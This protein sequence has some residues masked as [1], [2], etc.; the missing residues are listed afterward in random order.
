M[1]HFNKVIK[2][3]PQDHNKA[4]YTKILKKEDGRIDWNKEAEK[5]ERMITVR[6][7]SSNFFIKDYSGL[8]SPNPLYLTLSL[9]I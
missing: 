5:I 6:V 1:A 7:V 4:T 9:I 3:I 8:T 2:Y